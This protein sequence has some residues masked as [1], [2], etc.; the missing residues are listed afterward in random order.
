MGFPNYVKHTK[1][2]VTYTKAMV[3]NVLLDTADILQ[4]FLWIFL[5]YEAWMANMFIPKIYF[6]SLYSGYLCDS[7]NGVIELLLFLLSTPYHRTPVLLWHCNWSW[8]NNWNT[9]TEN[10]LIHPLLFMLYISTSKWALFE[11]MLLKNL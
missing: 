8:M 1:T 9:K 4:S 7:F 3:S 2:S 6:Q 11:N 10:L 5:F